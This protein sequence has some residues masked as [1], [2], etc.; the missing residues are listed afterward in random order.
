M[1]KPLRHGSDIEISRRSFLVSSLA[2]G[3]VFG[4][5]HAAGAANLLPGAPAH[6]SVDAPAFE[7]TIWF[8]IDHSGLV[9]INV[10]K[11]E[12]GQHIGTA[13]ARILADELE[14]DWDSVH[15]VGVDTDPKWGPMVTG[16]STSVWS[17]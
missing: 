1:N 2:S 3:A 15:V 17:N 5:E 4:F 13:L 12:M 10:T 9:S 8:S 11:A 6:S 16:A 7:P 14:A